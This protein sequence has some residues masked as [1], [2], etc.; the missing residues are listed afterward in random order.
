MT[1]A[2]HRIPM[3]LVTPK[4]LTSLA[5]LRTPM[6]TAAHNPCLPRLTHHRARHTPTLTICLVDGAVGVRTISPL[7]LFS[8]NPPMS[9]CILVNLGSR[10]SHTRITLVLVQV[11]GG[12]LRM[13]LSSAPQARTNEESTWAD[14]QQYTLCT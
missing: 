5:V 6:T 8:A 9:H 1:L 14:T 12:G 4:V 2:A 3:T 7:V 11:L 13:Y 10:A